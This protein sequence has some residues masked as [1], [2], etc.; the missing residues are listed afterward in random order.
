MKWIATSVTSLAI[1][2]LVVSAALAHSHDAKAAIPGYVAKAVAD[3]GRAE[4]AK[5]A[6]MPP[7][8]SRSPA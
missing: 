1:A 4:D 2:G 5:I 3:P 7:S 6:A 8:S